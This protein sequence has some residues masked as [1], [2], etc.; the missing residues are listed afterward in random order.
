[1]YFLRSKKRCHAMTTRSIGLNSHKKCLYSNRT[2]IRYKKKPFYKSTGKNSKHKNMWFPFRRITN[3]GWIDKGWFAIPLYIKLSKLNILHKHDLYDLS[4][5]LGS[6]ENIKISY[7]LGGP[8]WN[9]KSGKKIINYFQ[10]KKEN[11]IIDDK[12]SLI[13]EVPSK[14]NNFIKN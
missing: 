8:F 3:N 13:S 10:L 7:S 6:I 1:M 5:R 2:I 14:I 11:I 12:F 9:T 4:A